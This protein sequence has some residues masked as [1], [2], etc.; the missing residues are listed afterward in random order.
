[1]CANKPSYFDD[2]D[3]EDDEMIQKRVVEFISNG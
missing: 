1:M 2:T 3:K